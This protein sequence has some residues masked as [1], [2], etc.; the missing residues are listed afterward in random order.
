[1]APGFMFIGIFLVLY[2]ICLVPV[3]YFILRK[4]DRKELAWITSLV[5]I[6]FFS[7]GAYALGYSIKGGRLFLRFASVVEGAANEDGFSAH[8][9]ATVFSPRQSRYDISVADAGA[10]ASEA[11]LDTS[12]FQQPVGDLTLVQDTKTHV[13]DVLKNMWDQRSFLFQSHIKLGGA[14]A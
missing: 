8:T 7:T 2:I 4:L 10:L 12:S 3:N 13:K 5:I 11:T 1:E 14:I 9:F 6:V